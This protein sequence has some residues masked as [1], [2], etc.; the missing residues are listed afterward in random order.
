MCVAKDKTRVFNVFSITS[1]VL[2]YFPY[3]GLGI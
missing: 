2:K 3:Y 1:L